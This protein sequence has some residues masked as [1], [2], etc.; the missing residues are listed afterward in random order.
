[1]LLAR[2]ITSITWSGVAP[3][4]IALPMW[5]RMPAV[6]RCVVTTSIAT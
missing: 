6:N 2:V 1:M 5:T 4:S 3:Y